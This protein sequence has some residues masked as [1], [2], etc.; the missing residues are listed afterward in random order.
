MENI[1]LIGIE[2]GKTLSTSIV[3]IATEK[4]FSVKNSPDQNC[5]NFWQHARQ[6]PSR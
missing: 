3:R 2:L 6:Q 1:A 4:Q 5:L